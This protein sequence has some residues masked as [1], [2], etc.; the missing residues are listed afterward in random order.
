MNNVDREMY[1][2]LSHNVL[3]IIYSATGSMGVTK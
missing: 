2:F 3:R 1:V